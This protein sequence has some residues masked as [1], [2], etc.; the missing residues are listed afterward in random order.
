[1]PWPTGSIP[2]PVQFRCLQATWSLVTS[3]SK[4]AWCIWR[5]ALRGGCLEV[6]SPGR[7]IWT[8]KKK[9][10]RSTFVLIGYLL[11]LDGDATRLFHLF[12][13]VQ[14]SWLEFMA[15]WS[16]ICRDVEKYDAWTDESTRS[17]QSLVLAHACACASIHTHTHTLTDWCQCVSCPH[18]MYSI[19]CGAIIQRAVM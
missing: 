16:Q 13:I 5:C 19:S 17:G 2:R 15:V 11:A 8:L 6:N 12:V 14:L 1:M 10:F 18:R 3:P 4:C 9:G 7:K